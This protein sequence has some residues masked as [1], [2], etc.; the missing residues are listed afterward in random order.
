MPARVP[1]REFLASALTSAAGVAATSVAATSLALPLSV[2][3]AEGAAPPPPFALAEVGVAELQRRMTRGT[4]TSR[5]ITQAYLARIAAIPRP[6]RPPPLA[7][8]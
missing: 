6:H 1:R 4:T 8:P 7:T 5:A 2:A 3:E